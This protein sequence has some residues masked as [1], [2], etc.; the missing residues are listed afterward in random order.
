VYQPLRG[1]DLLPGG[2][3]MRVWVYKSHARTWYKQVAGFRRGPNEQGAL[4]SL[5]LY[6]TADAAGSGWPG[7]AC[8]G[9][10]RPLHR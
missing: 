10:N 3:D 2:H 5:Q 6:H 8:C 1:P 7:P 4:F 9:G